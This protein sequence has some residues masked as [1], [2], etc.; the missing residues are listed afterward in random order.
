MKQALVK[1]IKWVLW[2]GLRNYW[3]AA[4]L[5]IIAATM[6]TIA[7][8]VTEKAQGWRIPAVGGREFLPSG[9][10]VQETAT[11]LVSVHVALVALYFSAALLVLTLAAGSLGIRL[12]DRW[13]ARRTTRLTICLL[14]GQLTASLIILQSIAADGPSRDLPRYSLLCLILISIATFCWLAYALHDLARTIHV[15]LELAAIANATVDDP[16]DGVTTAPA[17]APDWSRATPILSD[18]SGYIE[19]LD[20]PRLKKWMTR[21]NAVVRVVLAVGDPVN[22][23]DPIALLIGGHPDRTVK[24][25]R[26]AIGIG[27]FRSTSQ[28]AVF[29]VRLIVEI[30]ARALSPA[31]NDFYTGIA[32]VDALGRAMIGQ[33]SRPEPPHWF[34]G[35][36][37]VARVRIDGVGFAE[38]FDEPLR[39]LRIAA[40]AYPQVAIR[41]IETL[42]RASECDN[43]RISL[44]CRNHA[45][46]VANHAGSYASFEADRAA[47]LAALDENRDFTKQT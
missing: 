22:L 15:D 37:G 2:L 4:L 32:A 38:L 13:I 12:I 47:I 3:S 40:A 41:L 6:L 43:D 9:N 33:W 27:D 25:I 42:R 26:S 30:A 24:A 21:Q 39:A 31:I 35:G 16:V 7:L 10:A 14:L 29:E 19:T 18:D 11:A 45:A 44:F 28:G 5:S 46:D 34:A 20:V 8:L 17:D 1:P 36:D 23:G